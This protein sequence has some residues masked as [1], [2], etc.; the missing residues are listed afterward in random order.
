MILGA[1]EVSSIPLISLG[2]E[3]IRHNCIER[4]CPHPTHVFNITT[5]QCQCR[6]PHSKCMYGREIFDDALCQCACPVDKVRNSCFYEHS[7]FVQS[8]CDCIPYNKI[9]KRIIQDPGPPPPPMAPPP[10]LLGNCTLV[11][12]DL[13][14]LNATI[15]QCVCMEFMLECPTPRPRTGTTRKTPTKTRTKTPKSR[16]NGRKR[17]HSRPGPAEAIAGCPELTPGGRRYRNRRPRSHRGTRM[18][19][20]PRTKTPTSTFVPIQSLMVDSCP[21]GQTANMVTCECSG[22][23]AG[24]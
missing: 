9:V 16:P 1:V 11:C 17:S 5:C 19:K 10:P 13:Q 18:S 14:Q 22:A 23:I 21:A 6:E 15:C 3:D 24:P 4:S 12:N 7:E 2:I 20:S 8:K